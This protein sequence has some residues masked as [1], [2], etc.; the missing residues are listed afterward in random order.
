MFFVTTLYRF[1]I[2]GRFVVIKVVESASRRALCAGAGP[3]HSCFHNWLL[4]TR[5]ER[6]G[7]DPRLIK[8]LAMSE[9]LVPRDLSWHPGSG[10][11]NVG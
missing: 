4:I 6:P 1:Q 5:F 3:G 11:N 9:A 7:L 8:F 10:S 2:I